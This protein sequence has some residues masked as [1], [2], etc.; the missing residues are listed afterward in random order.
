MILVSVAMSTVR[1][2]IVTEVGGPTW[3]WDTDAATSVRGDCARGP[4]RDGKQLVVEDRD[5]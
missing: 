3:Q 4:L 5:A 1:G 2:P